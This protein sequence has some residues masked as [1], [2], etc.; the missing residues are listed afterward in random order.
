MSSRS[1]KWCLVC[2]GWWKWK[3][4]VGCGWCVVQY[5]VGGVQYAVI[6]YS[7]SY[8][9]SSMSWKAVSAPLECRSARAWKW[10]SA[11]VRVV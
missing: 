3:W 11:E 4:C 8:M 2:R 7:M 6:V 9:A 10:E 1:Y 5:A